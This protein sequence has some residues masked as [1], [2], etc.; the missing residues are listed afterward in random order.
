MEL[1]N[2]QSTDLFL[3]VKILNKIGYENI[4]KEIN[5]DEIMGIRK[6]LSS[7]KDEDEQNKLITEYGI[8]IVM[9]VFG[10]L[11]EN[12]PSIEN[13][14]YNLV[15]SIANMKAKDVAK[16]DIN[17]FIDLLT[18]IINKEDFKDFFKRA[19]KLIKLG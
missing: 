8:N 6:K 5:V 7:I 11:L 3:F 14:L 16:M 10:I 4:R 1:R 17:K 19:S 9:S 15:G 2:L 12:I 13:D 18:E